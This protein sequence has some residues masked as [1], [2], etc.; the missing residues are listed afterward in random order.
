[1]L[2]QHLRLGRLLSES[3]IAVAGGPLAPQLQLPSA[4]ANLGLRHTDFNFVRSMRFFVTSV[5]SP[6][7]IVNIVNSVAHPSQNGTK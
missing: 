6:G 5:H 7:S 1:V 3:G 2:L 4:S